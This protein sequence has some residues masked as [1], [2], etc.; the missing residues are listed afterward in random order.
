M[1]E[2]PKLEI[3]NLKLA[4]LFWSSVLGFALRLRICLIF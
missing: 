2:N 4:L 3:R 1:K